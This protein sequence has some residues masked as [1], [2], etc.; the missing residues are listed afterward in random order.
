MELTALKVLKVLKA[1]TGWSGFPRRLRT[2]LEAVGRRGEPCLEVAAQP[3]G[4]ER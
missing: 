4:A 3:D 1:T 2:Y